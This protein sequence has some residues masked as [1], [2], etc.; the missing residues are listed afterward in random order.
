MLAGV[1]HV[2]PD[3]FADEEEERPQISPARRNDRNVAIRRKRLID[4][5]RL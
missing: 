5:R 3:P 2:S 4:W 1:G